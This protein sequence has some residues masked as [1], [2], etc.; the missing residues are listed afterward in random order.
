ML[1]CITYKRLNENGKLIRRRWEI[2]LKLLLNT[3]SSGCQIIPK[4]YWKHQNSVAYLFVFSFGTPFDPSLVLLISVLEYVMPSLVLLALL[5]AFTIESSA[6]GCSL[7]QLAPTFVSSLEQLTSAFAKLAICVF[8]PSW[9]AT[10]VP[11][12]AMSFVLFML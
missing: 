6:V 11:S 5:A 2:G 10:F 12:L 8:I 9:L 3:V 7:E 4:G 1:A